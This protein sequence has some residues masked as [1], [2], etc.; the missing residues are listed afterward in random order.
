LGVAL[1]CAKLPLSPLLRSELGTHLSRTYHGW[2]FDRR[3]GVDT[4]GLIERPVPSFDG[5]VAEH[6]RPY[7]GSNPSHFKRIVRSLNLRHQDFSFV[8]FGSG[9]GRVLLLAAAFPFRSIAGIEWSGELHKT[10][11]RNICI[12][13]GPRACNDIRSYCMDA[14]EFPVPQGKC[15]LYFFNPFKDEIVARVLDNIARS[16]EADPREMVIVYV[17]PKSRAV[18][19]RQQFIRTETDRGWFVVYRTVMPPLSASDPVSGRTSESAV[20]PPAA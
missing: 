2:T 1:L 14:A 11:A 15:V 5:C 16:F 7:G 18:L 9:K 17:N 12:Y 10:A 8:D 6:G 20:V 4:A 3:F 13:R 19:D